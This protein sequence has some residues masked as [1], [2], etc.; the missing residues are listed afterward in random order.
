MF[1]SSSVKLKMEDDWWDSISPIGEDPFRMVVRY[2]SW[3]SELLWLAIFQFMDPCFYQVSIST[4]ISAIQ[5]M[6]RS[7]LYRFSMNVE[8]TS[9][10]DFGCCSVRGGTWNVS[11]VFSRR[12]LD[13][14]SRQV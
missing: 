2:D 11:D 6:Q 10:V 7:F 5:V 13:A 14:L 8:L 12:W 1:R 4:A 3:A 9:F